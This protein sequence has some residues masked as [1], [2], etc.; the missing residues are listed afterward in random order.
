VRRQVGPADR[1]ARV[2]RDATQELVQ[3]AKEAAQVGV[4]TYLMS[5][6]LAPGV[7]FPA[8]IMMYDL[9]WP[10][11][12][13][14]LLESGDV[15]G[16]LRTAFPD[17]EVA[18][19]H[20]GPVARVVE[21]TEGRAG[22]GDEA[23]EVLTMRLVYHMPYPDDPSTLLAVRVNVPNIPSAEPFALLFDEIVDSIRFADAPEPGEP[24]EPGEL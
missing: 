6:E 1:L 9:A 14:A 7:P 22:D 11:P 23:V 4:H 15:A 2:R 24:G 16:A 5:L 19:Q 21:M 12:A 3:T 13:Q 8:A 10:G 17:G 18:T 20:Y